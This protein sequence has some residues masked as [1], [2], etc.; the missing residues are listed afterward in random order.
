[1]KRIKIPITLEDG[2][3]VEAMAPVIVSASRATDIPA[4]YSQWIIERLKAGYVVWTNPFN[5]KDSYVS[6][7]KC[8]VIVFWTKNP[9]PLMPYLNELDKRGIHYYFQY[10]LNDYE[11]ENLEPNVPSLEDRVKTFIE[12]SKRIGKER[13]IWRFDPI[14]MI[15]GMTVRQVLQRIWNVGNKIKGNTE[16]LVFSFIDVNGYRKVKRNM[17]NAT[18]VFDDINIERA[19]PETNQIEEIVDG[20]AKMRDYWKAEG[21]NIELATCAEGVDLSKYGVSHNRCVDAEL[22]KKVFAEDKDLI[23]YL[24]YGEMKSEGDLFGDDVNLK[25]LTDEDWKDK[26][27]RKACGCMESK[28]IGRYNT[29]KHFCAYCYANDSREAVLKNL[30]MEDAMEK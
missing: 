20:L 29:C 15:P 22:M 3:K 11:L 30:G 25:E 1:M 27:Q 17:V 12:L 9:R 28:D 8:K 4:F 2:T 5:R 7:N 14:V 24:K 18:Q 16:K 23:H 19:E 10:T 13:V 6:F 26:G 21:W